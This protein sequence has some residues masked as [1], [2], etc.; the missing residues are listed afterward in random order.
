MTESVVTRSATA[1]P[2]GGVRPKRVG[3]ARRLALAVPLAAISAVG[4]VACDNPQ[5]G[6]TAQDNATPTAPAAP[7]ASDS[8][9][10][11]ASPST[12]AAASP[13]P[14]AQAPNGTAGTALTISDGTQF[15]LMNGTSVDFGTPVRDLVWSPDGKKAAFINGT[16]DLAVANP[17]GTGQVVV[18]KNPG[19]QTW[20]HPAWQ[21]AAA[22]SQYSIPAKNN[23]I[24][25]VSEGGKLKLK[26]VSARATGAVPEVLSLGAVSG[27]PEVVVPPMTGNSWP[28]GG[29]TQGTSVYANEDGQVYIRD[30]YL[31]QQGGPITKG[32]EPALSPDG[33]DVVFVRSVDGH[34]HVFRAPLSREGAPKD[35]TPNA[36]TDF[37]EPAFSADGKTV[38]VRGA[39]GVYTLPVN[40]SAAPTKVTDHAGHPAYHAQG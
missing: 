40:G 13:S 19:G 3:R 34:A 29:G 2:A 11:S 20:T 12:S 5:H 16:G 22:D 21:V 27:G 39:D 35:L 17:D 32:S 37:H 14:T 4:L 33:H 28:S 24:F 18:A 25:T 31:R 7:T 26:R 1:V 38:A 6:D 23:L 10:A 30:E 15:V 36:T 8:A 9:A